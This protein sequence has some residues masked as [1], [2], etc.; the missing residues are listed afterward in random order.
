MADGGLVVGTQP[1]YFGSLHSHKDRTAVVCGDRRLTWAEL[2]TRVHR[3]ARAWEQLGLERGDKVAMFIKNCAE[4]VELVHSTAR[5][6]VTIVSL[7]FRYGPQELATAVNF[8][9]AR[10]IVVDAEL[11]PVL[12]QARAHLDVI[13][14]S[15]IYVLGS[16]QSQYRS[17][18]ELFGIGDDSPIGRRPDEDDILA[19]LFS[20]GTTG[21]PKAC[22]MPQRVAA[23]CWLGYGVELGVG[24]DDVQLAAGP[25]HHGLGF[26]YALC[27]IYMGATVVILRDF[28]PERALEAI[29]VEKVVFLPMAPTLYTM[30]LGVNDKK[31]FDVSSVRVVLSAGSPLRT[32]T[33]QRI[34]EYFPNSG[35]YEVYG[36]TEG[37]IYT[38]LKPADQLRKTRCAGQPFWGMEIRI[39]DDQGRDCPAGEIGTIYKRGLLMGAVYYKNPEATAAQFLDGWHTSGDMGYLDEEGYLYIADRKKDMIISGGVNIFPSEIEDVLSFH[40]AVR[41]AAVIGIPDETWGE[42]VCA[43]VVREPSMSVDPETLTELCR[44]K[45]AHYKT[46]RRFEFISELPKTAS[47]KIS[48]RQL[49]EPFWAGQE[50]RV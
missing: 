6:G 10:L 25:L 50:A 33:K 17:Y 29:E 40:P 42:Q 27:A 21:D 15:D 30:L 13:D 9:D 41:E 49:R 14:D 4:Y 3:L 43:I 26:Q 39:V 37:G 18:D 7:S 19:M 20:G 36:S 31:R 11:L 23:Q 32:A 45:L 5:V 38:V 8:S 24:Q 34:L 28:I 2:G 16:G 46:P 22:L 1:E 35:L 44:S 48:R 47:G 12:D